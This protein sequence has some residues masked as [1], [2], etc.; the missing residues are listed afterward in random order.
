[1][2]QIDYTSLPESM[3]FLRLKDNPEY[4]IHFTKETD[5]EAVYSV[6]NGYL[7]AAIWREKKAKKFMK[8]TGYANLEMVKVKDILNQNNNNGS[9]TNSIG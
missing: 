6:K 2:P 4:F 5:D 1:M 3:V 7:G 9:S 8:R